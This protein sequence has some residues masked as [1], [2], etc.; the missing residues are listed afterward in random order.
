[1][2]TYMKY[3]YSDHGRLGGVHEYTAMDN[4]NK[5]ALETPEELKKF[6][7]VLLKIHRRMVDEGY[8]FTKDGI[9]IKDKKAVMSYGN[10]SERE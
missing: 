4:D 8:R 10:N 1:M 2:H 7:T 9:R 6:G 5:I 3:W